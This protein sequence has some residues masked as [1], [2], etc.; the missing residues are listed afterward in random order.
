VVISKAGFYFKP[1]IV[2]PEVVKGEKIK[3]TVTK[4][5]LTLYRTDVFKS[6]FI[7]GYVDAEFTE[8]TT[9]AKGKPVIQKYYFRG[10]FKSQVKA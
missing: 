5:H 7:S 2:Y 8:I 9:M 1:E 6:K 4:Q 3:Y 10:Y